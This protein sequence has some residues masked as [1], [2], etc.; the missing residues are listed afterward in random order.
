MASTIVTDSS[1]VSPL[2][3]T[4]Y[5]AQIYNTLRTLTIKYPPLISACT[6][7]V[8][9]EGVLEDTTNPAAMK[10]YLNLQGEYAPTDTRMTVISLDT[11]QTI[12]FNKANL[13][14]NPQ[15]AAAYVPGTQYYSDLCDAYPGQTDLIKNIRYPVTDLQAAISAPAFTRLQIDTSF[16]E[17][18]ER[19]TIVNAID[20]MLN[21][22]YRR[23]YTP[24]Y[25]FEPYYP[26]V[27]Y[28][29]VLQALATA[30]FGARVRN[31][32]K[33]EVH[34]FHIWESLTSQG[35]DDYSD[36]LTNDQA[37]WLY[38]NLDYIM[39]NRGKQSNLIILAENILAQFDLTLHGRYVLNEAYSRRDQYLL[40]PVFKARTIPTSNATDAAVPTESYASILAKLAAVG[41]VHDTS[42]EAIVA[43]ENALGTVGKSTYP[44]K[45]LEIALVDKDRQLAELFATYAFETMLYTL[46]NGWYNGSVTIQTDVNRSNIITDPN[47]ALILLCYALRRSEYADPAE[48]G[49]PTSWNVNIVTPPTIPTLPTVL[50][51]PDG[52]IPIA[53]LIDVGQ[54]TQ[55]LAMSYTV[56]TP[57]DLSTNIVTGFTSLS[58][59]VTAMRGEVDY[60]RIRAMESIS[61]CYILSGK[62][63]LNLTTATTYAQWLAA[64]ESGLRKILSILDSEA[65][66]AT[67]YRDFAEEI[68]RG[69]I[70]VVTGFDTFGEYDVTTQL[71]SRLLGLFAQLT[72]F[73]VAYV[74]DDVTTTRTL[75][76]PHISADCTAHITNR[77]ETGKVDIGSD[78]AYGLNPTFETDIMLAVS[79]GELQLSYSATGD[80]SVMEL[81]SAMT[82]QTQTIAD[83][84]DLNVV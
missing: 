12:E 72:S 81:S 54:Y 28:N 58:N 83:D 19:D 38:R 46:A 36:I 69:L 5:N 22:V 59:Q 80:V 24:V 30:C 62:L 27:V 11:Q 82:D 6:D 43:G 29:L 65:D 34:S 17:V 52:V 84:I 37:H 63:P 51:T 18:N 9:A 45:V 71:Y 3:M 76:V 44:T 55:N 48:E 66:P 32:R 1:R 42:E 53:S 14:T 74:Y 10:Y 49:I 57:T 41:K 60:K 78:V 8:A 15:T 68:L 35:L 39:S 4:V 16:L 61:G 7:L 56:N 2:D 47:N 21:L 23:W 31:I 20:R 75:M 67:A 13:S 73:N 77:V 50:N 70:P 79:S 33:A 26:W 64:Q 40:T 25:E